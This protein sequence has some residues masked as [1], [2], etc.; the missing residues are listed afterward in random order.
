M[1]ALTAMSAKDTVPGFN[2]D[3]V[4]E[5]SSLEFDTNKLFMTSSHYKVKSLAV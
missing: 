4:K 3:L 5:I 1:N 2:R